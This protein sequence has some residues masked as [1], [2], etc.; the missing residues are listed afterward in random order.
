MLT[1]D[2]EGLHASHKEHGDAHCET[3]EGHDLRTA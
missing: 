2:D 3:P 1:F